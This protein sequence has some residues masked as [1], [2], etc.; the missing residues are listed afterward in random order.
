MSQLVE[1]SSKDSAGSLDRSRR[2][3]THLFTVLK[4]HIRQNLY[5]NDTLDTD[6]AHE[7]FVSRIQERFMDAERLWCGLVNSNPA[8]QAFWPS[9]GAPID[10]RAM[11]AEYDDSSSPTA[12]YAVAFTLQA[13]VRTIQKV[14]KQVA[15]QGTVFSKAQVVMRRCS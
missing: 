8:V 5:L 4:P 2:Y 3:A 13:G 1:R 14:A 6:D 10:R 12:E 9:H 15:E 11:I 7:S